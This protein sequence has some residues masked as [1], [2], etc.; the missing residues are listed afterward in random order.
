MKRLLRVLLVL[1]GLVVVLVAGV[2]VAAKVYFSSESAR[3]QVASH[4]A[5]AYGGR[6][7][8]ESADI[9]VLGDSSLRGLRLYE[10]GQPAG[11]PWASAGTVKTD[12][13][14][15]D[16]IRGVKPKELTL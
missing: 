9:G 11:E 14:V 15:I 12:V 3:H 4:L 16:L 2:L 13:S 7:E 1:V 5:E 8:V 10:A 6:V